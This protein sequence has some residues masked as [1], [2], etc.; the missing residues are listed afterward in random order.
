MNQLQVTEQVELSSGYRWG[1]GV[2]FVVILAA[3]VWAAMAINAWL[4]DEQRLPV[5]EIQ[6]MGD[7]R[8]LS[9]D[10][11]KGIIRHRFPGSFFELD[12]DQVHDSV[13]AMPWVYKVSVRKRWPNSLQIFVVEQRPVA[14]WNQDM[15]LNQYGESFNA[16]LPKD[17]AAVPLL[18]GPGGSEKTAMQGYRAMQMLLNGHGLK[19][20]ELLLTERFAWHVRLNNDVS[21]NLGRSEFI[22]RMQRFVDLYPLLQAD[23]RRVDYVDLRYDTGM[24]VGWQ[25]KREKQDV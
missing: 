7:I 5:Q 24:A 14:S 23:E 19:I 1:G 18:F 12:V 10:G 11:L 6:V 9:V 16:R 22:D 15:L 8:Y 13:L 21:L 20:N 17:A 2:V 25:H 3:L 4:K